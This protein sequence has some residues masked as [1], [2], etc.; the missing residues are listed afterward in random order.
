[1]K[2]PGEIRLSE[3]IR[4]RAGKLA[5][6]TNPFSPARKFCRTAKLVPSGLN[7]TH[8]MRQIHLSR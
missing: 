6:W 4:R 2:I 3:L 5:L 8:F 1:M 7:L